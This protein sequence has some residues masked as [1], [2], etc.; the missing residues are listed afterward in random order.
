MIK[1]KYLLIA[2]VLVG[3]FVL[4]FLSF[5]LYTP[6]TATIDI[7]VVF[8]EFAYKKELEVELNKV[9]LARQSILDSLKI[10]LENLNKSLSVNKDVEQRLIEYYKIKREEYFA[11]VEE[12]EVSNAQLAASYDEKIL[13]QMKQY[14]EDYGEENKYEYIYGDDGN[15]YIS[16]SSVNKDIT[17]EVIKYINN[18]F[19]GE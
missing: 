5:K 8:N 14:I 16:Y 11:K 13:S 17:E 6:K 9:K 7:K 18:R 12:F 19:G 1:G 15:G 3:V 4:S 10:Q 2:G